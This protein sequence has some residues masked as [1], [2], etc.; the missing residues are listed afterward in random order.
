MTPTA[1]GSARLPRAALVVLTTFALVAALA[2][3]AKPSGAAAPVEARATV[4]ASDLGEITVG[5]DGGLWSIRS[6]SPLTL[7]RVDPSGAERVVTLTGVG[8]EP[9]DLA[10]GLGGD[11]VWVALAD[12]IVRV[13]GDGTASTIP[14]PAGVRLAGLEPEPT[15]ERMWFVA[16]DAQPVDGAWV[17]AIDESGAVVTRPTTVPIYDDA[18]L[19]AGPADTMWALTGRE[20]GTLLRI[21]R[22]QLDPRGGGHGHRRAGARRRR[23]PVRARRR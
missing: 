6:T 1:F 4:D 15:G 11:A 2:T 17:G 3:L 8:G 10:P 19:V 7:H 18:E 23:A 12:R 20:V 13:F 9:A 5:R 14:A 16:T 22:P 21:R